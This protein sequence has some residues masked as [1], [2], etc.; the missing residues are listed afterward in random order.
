M[1]ETEQKKSKRGTKSPDLKECHGD[2]LKKKNDERVK[3]HLKAL[4][5]CTCTGYVPEEYQ[6]YTIIAETEVWVHV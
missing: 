2:D 3:V 6:E 4:C 5:E 1:E